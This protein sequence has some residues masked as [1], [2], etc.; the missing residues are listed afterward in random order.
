M[1]HIFPVLPRFKMTYQQTLMLDECHQYLMHMWFQ[2]E[3]GSAHEIRAPVLTSLRVLHAP[4]KGLVTSSMVGVMKFF[5][6]L[7]DQE[8]M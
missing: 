2:I 1:K 7:L 3:T 4:P 5:E 6:I 8:K